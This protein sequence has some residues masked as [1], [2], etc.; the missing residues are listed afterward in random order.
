MSIFIFRNAFFLSERANIMFTL[1]S[2][3]AFMKLPDKE[4]GRQNWC[5]RPT[6]LSNAV[7]LKYIT[8]CDVH[9]AKLPIKKNRNEFFKE[10]ILL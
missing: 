10:S 9:T 3:F 6:I 8:N 4:S 7:K 2:C 5:H 1:G